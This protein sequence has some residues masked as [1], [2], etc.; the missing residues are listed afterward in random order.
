M[1]NLNTVGDLKRALARF[2]DDLVIE[3]YTDSD[4]IPRAVSLM[5]VKPDT[6]ERQGGAYEV[7]CICMD[8]LI[9]HAHAPV[10]NP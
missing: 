5:H 7:L 1:A 9:T 8:T 6:E 10:E 2:P 3:V 4:G